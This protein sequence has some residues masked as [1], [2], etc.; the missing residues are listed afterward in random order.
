VLGALLAFSAASPALS[1]AEIFNPK[2][3]FTAGDGAQS[4]AIG[5]LN[6]DGRPDLATANYSAGNVSVLLA[7]GAQGN[8]AA[9]VNFAAGVGPAGVTPSQ[10]RDQKGTGG[11]L[12]FPVDRSRLELS[13]QARQAGL[14]AVHPA[15]D[16][17]AQARPP[18]L[19][20]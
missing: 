8:F 13:L 19:Q 16:L 20:G 5:D 18:R 1:A 10:D 11:D 17:Q 14:Q 2:V 3:D 12:C 15:Q 6:G 7:T 9:P 4:V